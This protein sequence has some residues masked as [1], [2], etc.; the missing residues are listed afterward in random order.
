VYLVSGLQSFFAVTPAEPGFLIAGA[1]DGRWQQQDERRVSPMEPKMRSMIF[2][3]A[4]A[5]GSPIAILNAQ[6]K[7]IEQAIQEKIDLNSIN[8]SDF[9][10]EAGILVVSGQSREVYDKNKIDSLIA[11]AR[12]D[13][14]NIEARDFAVISK[15]ETGRFVSIVYRVTLTHTQGNTVVTSRNLSHEIWEHG[16]SGWRELFGAIEQ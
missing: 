10:D 8:S 5:C 11:A 2:V 3:L 1:R 12:S 6:E 4:V 16:P 14:T 15:S 13:G 9:A 7:T